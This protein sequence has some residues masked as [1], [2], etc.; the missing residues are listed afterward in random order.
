MTKAFL[1]IITIMVGSN[2]PQLL[3]TQPIPFA[4]K[5][6]CGQAASLVAS[7]Y[8]GPEPIKAT[9]IED[10]TGLKVSEAT[11]GKKE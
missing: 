3:I 8:T 5:E 2:G 6:D 10:A 7:F 11:K 9:C 1:L 4:D